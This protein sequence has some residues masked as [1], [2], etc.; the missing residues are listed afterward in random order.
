MPAVVP[1][2]RPPARPRSF[3]GT[4]GTVVVTTDKALLWTDGR[5]FL[6]ASR[7][8]PC[9]SPAPVLAYGGL[10]RPRSALPAVGRP[11]AHRA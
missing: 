11:V 7:A 9:R 8:A 2:T 10:W 3:T 6:Q 1:P 4:A 5:Y